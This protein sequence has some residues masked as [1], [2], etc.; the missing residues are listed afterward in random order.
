MHLY[1]YSHLEMQIVFLAF[2]TA[3]ENKATFVKNGMPIATAATCLLNSTNN[4]GCF[5]TSEKDNV[6]T[7]AL[8]KAKTN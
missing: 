8:T 6:H 1:F 3:T 2:I 5:L 7:A 4:S